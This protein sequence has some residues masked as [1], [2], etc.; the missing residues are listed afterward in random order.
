MKPAKKI[1][2]LI[3][4]SRYKANPETY[5][6]ALGSFLQAVDA[7]KK[8]KPVLT[9]PNIWRII[10]KSNI[11]KLA[12]AAVIFI[13]IMLGMYVMTGSFDG[14]SITM[15]QVREAMENIDWVQMDCRADEKVISVW[16]SFASKVQIMVDD[17]GKIIYFDFNP[18]KRLIWNPD[19]E[20]IYE[21]DINEERQFAGGVSNIYEGLTKSL[22]SWEAEGKYKV[23]REN[24][25]YQGQKIEI[26]TARRIKGK[27]SLTRTELMTMYIDVEKKLPLKATDIKGAH[28][29]IQST[30]VVEF[31]YPETGP[32]DIYEAGAP[33]SAKIKPS[34]E[35]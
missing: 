1:E 25:T 31:K 35:Q 2:R 20:V 19:S 26:W 30:N 8:Q 24:G 16:Y 34:E 29:D 6:T 18:G 17:K 11:T 4:K 12:A 21:S 32:A 10:M 3:K 33:R 5:D 23:T 22:H 27:P 7:H 28:G 14:T 9:E 13:A 15:A